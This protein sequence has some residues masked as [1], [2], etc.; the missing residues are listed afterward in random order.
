MTLGFSRHRFCKVVWNSSSQIWCELHEE[1]FAYFGGVARLIRLDN[2]REGV[3]DP[4]IYDPELNSLYAATL[5]HYSVT[6][7]PCRP[8]APDLTGCGKTPGFLLCAGTVGEYNGGKSPRF[9]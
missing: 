3:V 8:Y 7:I 9:C 5:A 2:L 1:A 6:A 4:D